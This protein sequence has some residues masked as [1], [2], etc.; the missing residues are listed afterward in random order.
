MDYEQIV[1]EL[2]HGSEFRQNCQY[3]RGIH[4]LSK[5]LFDLYIKSAGRL[6]FSGDVIF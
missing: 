3:R 2:I 1:D 6:I 4:A 5:T